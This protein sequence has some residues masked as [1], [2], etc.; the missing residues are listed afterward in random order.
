MELCSGV[1]L[2]EV[3]IWETCD[4]CLL[5]HFGQDKTVTFVE[6]IFC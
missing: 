1:F 6:E 4:E 2:Q 5:G 3:I